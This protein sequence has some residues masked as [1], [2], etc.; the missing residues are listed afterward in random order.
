MGLIV[1]V[2]IVAVIVV[3]VLVAISYLS[4]GSHPQLTE[5]DAVAEVTNFI[6]SAYPNSAVNVT[7]NV[8]PSATHPGNWT[9]QA[10]AIINGTK[11]C[12]SDFVYTFEVPAYA[13]VNRTQNVLALNCHVDESTIGSAPIAIAWTYA[14]NEPQI[15]QV[16]A[17][18][19]KY[20]Y[21][22]V[23]VSAE[24]LS[25]YSVNGRNFTDVWLVTYSAPLANH[26][27]SVVLNQM[28]GTAAYVFNATT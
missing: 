7:T 17:F 14:D 11:P 9:I 10:Q 23:T 25:N 16:H 18:V 20:S 12:P 8:T 24:R 13:L 4:G 6:K 26:T 21:S 22:N 19:S 5:A 28:N 2:F 1:N 15:Q 27:V 3:I